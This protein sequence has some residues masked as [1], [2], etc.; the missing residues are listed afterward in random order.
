MKID[1]NLKPGDITLL[2]VLS[3]VLIIFFLG[4]FIILPGIGK[5][6]DLVADKENAEQTK[7]EMQDTI[8]NKPL[9]EKMVAKQK[10]ELEEASKGY[11]RPM[12]NREVDE[13]VTGLVLEH[14]LFPVYLNISDPVSGVPAAYLSAS[15]TDSS[16]STDSTES[17]EDS[18]A[19]D[20][21]DSSAST[22]SSESAEDAL[23][24]DDSSADGTDHSSLIYQHYVST[25]NVDVTLQGTEDNIRALFDDIANN[26]PGI[27]VRSFSMQENTYV[28]SSMQTVGMMNCSCVLAIYTCEDLTN[29]NTEGETTN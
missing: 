23:N 13:L 25:I 8:D 6:Q 21:E 22:D 3:C 2:K 11:Y 20:S 7:Q 5:H 4:Y 19:S 12:A 16:A 29:G 1:M 14:S 26:Y 17:A 24:G 28:D 27:Q 10:S 15:Q 18:G 9:Y